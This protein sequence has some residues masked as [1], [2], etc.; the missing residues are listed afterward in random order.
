[1]I[2]GRDGNV[3]QQEAL[4]NLN[5]HLHRLEVL[6]FDQMA[7]IAGA[8]TWVSVFLLVGVRVL[9]SVF[10]C[11][12]ARNS[13]RTLYGGVWR[14]PT[15]VRGGLRQVP[16]SRRQFKWSRAAACPCLILETVREDEVL[17]VPDNHR[18]SAGRTDDRGL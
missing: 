6:T 13:L 8:N 2:I 7:R 17:V 14:Y 18:D 11:G 12:D 16:L 15:P 10:L 4:P 1:M 9:V 5:S 3:I